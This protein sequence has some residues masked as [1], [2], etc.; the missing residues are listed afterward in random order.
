MIVDNGVASAVI[1]RG[2]RSPYMFFVTNNET[3]SIKIEL[4]IAFLVNMQH[5]GLL[6]FKHKLI[7]GK[8]EIIL[9]NGKLF[10]IS[11]VFIS[12]TK[13]IPHLYY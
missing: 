7:F 13:I 12:R 5:L 6:L 11:C 2:G 3:K 8:R 9:A 4:T 1:T 10:P